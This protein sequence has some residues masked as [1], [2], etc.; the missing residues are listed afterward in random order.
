MVVCAPCLPMP[1]GG[2]QSL[3]KQPARLPQEDIIN[4]KVEGYPVD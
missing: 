1:Y 3:N 2:G 4:V